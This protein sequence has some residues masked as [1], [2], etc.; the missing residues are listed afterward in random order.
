MQF[1]QKNTARLDNFNYYSKLLKKS[2]NNNRKSFKYFYLK[3]LN[4]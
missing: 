3:K 2:D 4:K 1:Y